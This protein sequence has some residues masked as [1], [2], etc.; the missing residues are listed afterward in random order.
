MPTCKGANPPVRSVDSRP[1]RN[2]LAEDTQAH[3]DHNQDQQQAHRSKGLSLNGIHTPFNKLVH[4]C[5]VFRVQAV[6]VA[7]VFFVRHRS[8]SKKRGEQLCVF[9]PLKVGKSPRRVSL[10]GSR[11]YQNS[12]R[13]TGM[14][15]RLSAPDSI[16]SLCWKM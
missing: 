2:K 4:A 15:I 3:H 9:S 7:I 1:A 10:P 12:N 16:M 8:L 6:L 13:A 14:S 11:L 5:L